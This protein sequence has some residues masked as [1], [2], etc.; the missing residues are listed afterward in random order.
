MRAGARLPRVSDRSLRSTAT[1]P[2]PR[3]RAGERSRRAKLHGGE[4]GQHCRA[5]RRGAAPARRGACARW[6]AAACPT[7]WSVFDASSSFFST[8]CRTSPNLPH[9]VLTAPSTCQTS[10]ERCWMASVRKPICSAVQHRGE[11]GRAGDRRPQLAL[12]HLDEARRGARPRRRAPRS[13]GT[14]SAKSVVARRVQVLVADVLARSAQ[15]ASLERA[16][17][18]LD[19][20]RVAALGGLDEPLVVLHRELRVDGEQHLARRRRRG[21][22]AAP[23]TRPARRRSRRS[24][25]SCAYCS[26][27]STCSSRLPS[28]TSPQVPRTF[29]FARTFLRSPTPVASVCISP[30]PCGPPRAARRRA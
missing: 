10:L 27:A 20:L 26:G 23:R 17:R 3:R 29:T 7:S 28:W 14:G 11:R 18:R 9:S 24:R 4:L 6:R 19:G 21:R 13:G 16:R 22:A 8:F 1:S 12:Q 2:R 5:R 25:R 30:S 15:I